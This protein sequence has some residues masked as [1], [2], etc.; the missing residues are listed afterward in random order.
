MSSFTPDFETYKQ[1]WLNLSNRPEKATSEQH[2]G[3]FIRRALLGEWVKYSVHLDLQ[4]EVVRSCLVSL[5]FEIAGN[6]EYS[7]SDYEHLLGEK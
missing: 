1:I 6:V 7:Y 2:E 4:D 5:I 3:G